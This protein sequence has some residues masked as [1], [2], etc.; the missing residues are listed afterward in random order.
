[1]SI[2]IVPTLARAP[3]AATPGEATIRETSAPAGARVGGDFASILLG[4]PLSVAEVPSPASQEGNRLE[5]DSLLLRLPLAGTGTSPTGETPDD[6]EPAS[7]DAGLG[8]TDPALLAALGVT[9]P[10]QPTRIDASEGVAAT[11]SEQTRAG[12]PAAAGPGAQL[13]PPGGV[14]A[15]TGKDAAAPP[16]ATE[17]SGGRPAD[18]AATAW[19]SASTAQLPELAA[20]TDKVATTPA[21]QVTAALDETTVSD[22]LFGNNVQPPPSLHGLPRLQ[23]VP[24]LEKPLHDRSWATDLGQKLLWFVSNDKQ[25]AQLT[26]NPPQLGSIEITIHMDKNGANAHFASPNPDVRGAIETAVPRLREMFAGAGIDLGQ[27]S[28]GGESFRQHSD[29][30][31]D[32]SQ[33]P[34]ILADKAILGGGS[35]GGIPGAAAITRHGSSLVDTFA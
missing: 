18:F 19:A 14:P 29:G 6:G 23:G 16:P 17:A 24:A 13:P 10:P 26:L 33:R 3:I 11:L 7:A 5:V 21:V 32:T 22:G 27:V 12:I 8:T 31:Q 28:V 35:A 25:G 1:M 15:A 4:L 9:L 2:A 20:S 30:Q 34:R